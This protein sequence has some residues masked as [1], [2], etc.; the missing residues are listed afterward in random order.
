MLCVPPQI[1]TLAASLTV[2]ASCT[3]AMLCAEHS[4][5]CFECLKYC[6]FV[7][8]MCRGDGSQHVS[9]PYKERRLSHQSSAPQAAD[10]YPPSC[11]TTHVVPLEQ[12]MLLPPGH[13][14]T[15]VPGAPQQS[16]PG[17]SVY[18]FS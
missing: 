11:V 15:N 8:L 14:E 9:G 6:L 4:L 18:W 12:H 17:L 13:F 10:G 2:F 5:T 3:N 7:C 16:G 1:C